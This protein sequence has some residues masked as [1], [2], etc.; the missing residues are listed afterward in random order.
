MKNLVRK[1]LS[2][3][4]TQVDG[5]SRTFGLWPPPE[6]RIGMGTSSTPTAGSWTTS[7]EPVIPWAHRY[8]DP[9][10]AKALEAKVESAA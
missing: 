4:I 6:T 5:E 2:A 1:L 9:P 3:E 8:S 7:E 10:V